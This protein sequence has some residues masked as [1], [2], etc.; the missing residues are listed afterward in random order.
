MSAEIVYSDATRLAELIRTHQVPPFEVVQALLDRIQAINPELK[1]VVNL[2]ADSVDAARAAEKAAVSILM[3]RIHVVNG[4]TERFLRRRLSECY[5]CW[6]SSFSREEKSAKGLSGKERAKS[7]SSNPASSQPERP[8]VT[9]HMGSS[10]GPILSAAP[11]PPGLASEASVVEI[12][13]QFIERNC[14]TLA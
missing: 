2:A 8:P 11:P 7:C 12:N 6:S 5:V 10:T 1:V 9:T 4:T 13:G 14:I 3:L